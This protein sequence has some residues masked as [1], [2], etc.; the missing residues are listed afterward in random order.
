[1]ALC[2]GSNTDA[3]TRQIRLLKSPH[4]AGACFTDQMDSLLLAASSARGRL[5]S[6]LLSTSQASPLQSLLL[7]LL[8]RL[9]AAWRFLGASAST[10]S[11]VGTSS[12]LDGRR[13]RSSSLQTTGSRR[14][15][16]ESTHV[17]LPRKKPAGT[18]CEEPGRLHL[19]CESFQGLLKLSYSCSRLNKVYAYFLL[20][21]RAHDYQQGSFQTGLERDQ[22]GKQDSALKRTP[23][24]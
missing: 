7:L 19:R 16:A 4:N 12:C 24:L 11:F 22:E 9:E 15:A 17:R 3:K 23:G 5:L 14:S 13:W 1:M 8:R 6:H 10:C 20:G 18:F 21:S 2:C